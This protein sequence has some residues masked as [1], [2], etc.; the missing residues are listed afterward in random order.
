MKAFLAVVF[1]FGIFAAGWGLGH[2]VCVAPDSAYDCKDGKC[3][4]KPKKPCCKAAAGDCQ[5][6][7]G[8]MCNCGDGECGCGPACPCLGG[9]C[10][11]VR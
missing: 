9:S 5:C 4:P 1:A 3:T 10:K 11:P 2:C 6:V 7:Q 8:G